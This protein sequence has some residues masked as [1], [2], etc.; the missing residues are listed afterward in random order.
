MDE[1]AVTM[2][3][4]SATPEKTINIVSP[5][6]LAAFVA[7]ISFLTHLLLRGHAGLGINEPGFLSHIM[8][9]FIGVFIFSVW[10][11]LVYVAYQIYKI[12]RNE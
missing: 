3:E 10:G 9:G 6:I 7:M 8:L 1:K 4:K 12:S 11:T 5:I 2:D